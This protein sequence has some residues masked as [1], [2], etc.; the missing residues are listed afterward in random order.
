MDTRRPPGPQASLSRGFTLIE[1]L[2]VIAI[3]AVLI[4]LLLPA[5][6]SAREAARRAQ[7]TNNLKQIGLALHNYHSTHNVFPPGRMYPDAVIGGVPRLTLTSYGT[8][9]MPDAPGNW[10]GYYSV[11][12]HILNYLEQVNAYNAMNFAGVNLGSLQNAAGQIIAANYTAYT[13]TQ[14]TFLCPSDPYSTGDGPGGENNYRAN[15]GGSTPYAGGGVRGDNTP[16]SGT[17]NGVFTY[18]PG[19]SIAGITDGTSNT[20]AFAE[21]TKGSNKQSVPGTSSDN[22]G[23]FGFTFTFNPLADADALF[24][25][26]LNG[27]SSTAWFYQQGRYAPSPGFGLQF[28][29]GWA[30]A[31][32][33]AT[34]Y[35]H[36]APPNWIGVDCGVGSTI[37]DTPGEHSIV[38]ARSQHP[39]GV[40]S[41][42]ADGSVRFVKD[43]VSIPT[44]RALGT[45]AGGEVL[46]ADSY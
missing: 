28:S 5:V 21:R 38:S 27:R 39:G 40:N 14:S 24:Q 41:L 3:I 6:Q 10:T 43:S 18:G 31:W 9:N 34:L 8:G 12:C 19:I 11:H 45:R 32:Y 30:Y 36:V 23:I 33:V 29:D 15:F 2:V 16:K 22:I 44:W 13:L 7:C 46:S 42:L 26:C 37:M 1:L 25:N 35:N 17:D 20:S 4:S